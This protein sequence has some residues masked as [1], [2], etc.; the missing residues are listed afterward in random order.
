MS[1]DGPTPMLRTYALM[2]HGPTTRT[3]STVDREVQNKLA[4]RKKEVTDSDSES[5]LSRE[6]WWGRQSSKAQLVSIPLGAWL[7][8]NPS[9]SNPSHPATKQANGVLESWRYAGHHHRGI[10]LDVICIV[11]ARVTTTCARA[12]PTA[13]PAN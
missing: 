13:L 7:G 10:V 4:S 1:T 8:P 3:T 6:R 9:I 12:A 11:V 2:V 5:G